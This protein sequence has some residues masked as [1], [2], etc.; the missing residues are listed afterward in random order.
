[1]GLG[2]LPP[3]VP[4]ETEVVRQARML[5]PSSSPRAESG[6]LDVDTLL[7]W[8][9]PSRTETSNVVTKKAKGNRQASFR[10]RQINEALRQPTRSYSVSSGPKTGFGVLGTAGV[11]PPQPAVEKKTAAKE[12]LPVKDAPPAPKPLGMG[13][14]GQK[15]KPTESVSESSTL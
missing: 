4:P 13:V 11:K 6:S 3:L 9:T 14:V 2:A 8:D 7:G 1:M 15:Q 5:R 12:P 10:K